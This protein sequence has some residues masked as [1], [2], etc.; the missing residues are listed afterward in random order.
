MGGRRGIKDSSRA[1]GRRALAGL[2]RVGDR[3]RCW[4]PALALAGAVA[5]LRLRSPS[6]TTSPRPGCDR[7]ALVSSPRPPPRAHPR[8]RADDHR[9]RLRSEQR[10]PPAVACAVAVPRSAPA[11]GCPRVRSLLEVSPGSRLSFNHPDQVLRAFA[12]ATLYQDDTRSPTLNAPVFSDVHPARASLS[13][14]RC[15]TVPA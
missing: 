13:S 1:A 8:A 7:L 5:W 2:G 10:A 9:A 14:R 6:T 4:P 12:F 3:R 15:A 11:S